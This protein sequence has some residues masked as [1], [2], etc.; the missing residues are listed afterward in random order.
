MQYPYSISEKKLGMEVIFGM[1]IKVKVSQVGI[2]PFDGSG[3]I[4]PKYPKQ[5]VSKILQY[6][7]KNC[8]NCFAFCCDAKHSDILRGSSH[9]R[10]Y[11]FHNKNV[12]N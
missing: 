5:E 3:Q 6:I 8:R 12:V 4:G 9:V 11:L 10:C 2:I 1:L 7:K